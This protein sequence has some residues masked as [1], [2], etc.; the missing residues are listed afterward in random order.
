MTIPLKD[1]IVSDGG[2]RI[3]QDRVM[4]KVALR[5]V[6]MITKKSDGKELFLS[7]EVSSEIEDWMM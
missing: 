3:C 4:S 1:A 6:L 5:Y 2:G 7:S